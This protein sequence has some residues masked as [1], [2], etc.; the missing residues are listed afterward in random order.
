MSTDSI[1]GPA[2][3]DRQRR[4]LLRRISRLLDLPMT[5]L[6]FVWLGLLIVEFTRGLDPALGTLSVG[7]WALFIVHFALEFWIAPEKIRYLRTNWRWPCYCR[8]CGGCEYFGRCDYFVRPDSRGALAW[9]GGSRRSI[10][11]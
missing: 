7:L 8:L 10:A 5:I 9:R 4:S 2:R 3:L 1:S 11:A 6:S